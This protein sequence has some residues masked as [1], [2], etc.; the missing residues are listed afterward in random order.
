MT[1]SSKGTKTVPGRH[2]KQKQG[3]NRELL[4]LAHSRFVDLLEYK[5]AKFGAILIKVDP[6]NTSRTCPCCGHTSKRNR[7]SQA[8][9]ECVRCGYAANADTNAAFNILCRGIGAKLVA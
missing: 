6:K 5:A 3:L 8:V 2:V 4:R 1:K 7:K 9:F